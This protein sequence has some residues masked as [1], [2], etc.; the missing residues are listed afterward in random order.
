MP[1]N[2]LKRFKFVLFI[3]SLTPYTFHS[4]TEIIGRPCLVVRKEDVNNST[5][6]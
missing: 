4:I 2:Y 1:K 5:C 3:D 6:V